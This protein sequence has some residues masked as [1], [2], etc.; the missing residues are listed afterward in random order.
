MTYKISSVKAGKTFTTKDPLKDAAWGNQ[1]YGVDDCV[2]SV[3]AD[4]DPIEEAAKEVKLRE[5]NQK[6][7]ELAQSDY[8]I[9]KKLEKLLPTD[10]VDVIERQRK[11]DRIN[12][13]EA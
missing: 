13:L 1:Y 6:K 9:L 11:R 2:V 5:I 7:F 4:L 3:V 12:E 8:K 10:D